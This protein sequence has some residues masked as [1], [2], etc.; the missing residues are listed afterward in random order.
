MK[1]NRVFTI[2]I[3]I[4]VLVVAF[5]IMLELF[6]GNGEDYVLLECVGGETE[7]T[8]TRAST[9]AFEICLPA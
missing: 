1:K 8:N 3:Y 9:V 4:A 5:S 7:N 2:I 6:G